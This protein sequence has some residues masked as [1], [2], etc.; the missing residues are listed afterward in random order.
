[1]KSATWIYVPNGGRDYRAKIVFLEA[2]AAHVSSAHLDG[3]AVLL[4]GDLNV[5]RTE[6]DVHPQ[7]R[8]PRAVGQRPE[9]RPWFERIMENG[10]LT[11]VRRQ[12]D[13]HNTSLY[14]WWVTR[15][16]TAY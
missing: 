6:I 14:A 5:A 13:P 8:T 15:P 1:M 2:L 12:P 7:G 11:D 10:G 9:E 16:R 4:C 3:R